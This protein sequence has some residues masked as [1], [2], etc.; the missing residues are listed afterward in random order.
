MI[1]MCQGVN[2]TCILSY[3]HSC[4]VNCRVWGKKNKQTFLTLCDL[5][6]SRQA[7]HRVG[8][9]LERIIPM[10]VQYSKVE[11][12]DELREYCIQVRLIQ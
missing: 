3:V 5:H 1:A 7:G 6:F 9:H 2:T 12:D 8:E 10:I 4:R 11:N